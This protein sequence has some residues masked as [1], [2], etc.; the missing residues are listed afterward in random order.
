MARESKLFVIQADIKQD[1][2]VRQTARKDAAS[3]K[4]LL[5]NVAALR[6]I[7]T[8]TA[9]LYPILDNH[10]CGHRL[11]QQTTHEML[12]YHEGS[13]GQTFRAAVES[14]RAAKILHFQWNSSS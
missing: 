10:T 2:I 13:K 1:D 7:P 11:H 4:R 8:E 3:N 5:Q 9:E 14:N 6:F 12:Q